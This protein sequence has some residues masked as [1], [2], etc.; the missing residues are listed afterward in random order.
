[1]PSAV[2]CAFLVVFSKISST[3]TE[4]TFLNKF[5]KETHNTNGIYEAFSSFANKLGK[6]EKDELSKIQCKENRNYNRVDSSD[7]NWDPHD[8][9]GPSPDLH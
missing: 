4:Y 8:I 5:Y 6:K 1:M 9:A 7:G 2:I 3:T